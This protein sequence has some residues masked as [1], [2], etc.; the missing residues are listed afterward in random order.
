MEFHYDFG[1]MWQ[2]DVQLEEIKPAARKIS[3][4][5]IVASRGEAPP[6]YEFEDDW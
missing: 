3:K 4:A 2:F 1:A 6:E 5:T